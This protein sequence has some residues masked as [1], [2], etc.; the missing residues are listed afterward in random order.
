MLINP[1][2]RVPV[3]EMAFQFSSDDLDQAF[4][5]KDQGGTDD[6]VAMALKERGYINNPEFDPTVGN[7]TNSQLH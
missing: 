4:E 6:D 5:L 3:E 1:E 7:K 2:Q